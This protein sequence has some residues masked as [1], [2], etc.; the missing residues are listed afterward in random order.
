[1]GRA[2]TRRRLTGWLALFALALQFAVSLGHIHREDFAGIVH[3]G[4]TR[5]TPADDA[6]AGPSD[7][8]HLTCDICATVHLI[9]T[10]AVPIPAVLAL[11]VT[12]TIIAPVAVPIA[13]APA[14]VAAFD[15]RGPP[16]A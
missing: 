15:A 3:P 16:Q 14:L 6:P 8:D 13:H 5:A 2:Q 4:V 9:G 11:P 1:M 7:P 10:S 12:T